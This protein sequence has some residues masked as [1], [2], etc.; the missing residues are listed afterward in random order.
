MLRLLGLRT[1]L[2]AGLF[3]VSPPIANAQCPDGIIEGDY[4]IENSADA[5]A[6]AECTTITGS[7]AVRDA[8][9]VTLD[10]P[11]LSA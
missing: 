11:A 2:L 7:L 8:E 5:E 6:I 3:C 10:L 9:L 4:T 1:V